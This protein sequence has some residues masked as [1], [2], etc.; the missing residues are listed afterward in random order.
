MHYILRAVPQCVFFVVG[1]GMSYLVNDLRVPG[2]QPSYCTRYC[3][4][5]NS[6]YVRKIWLLIHSRKPVGLWRIV[7]S[8]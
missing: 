1:E 7:K 4:L 5:E 3:T 8:T 6:M 2:T